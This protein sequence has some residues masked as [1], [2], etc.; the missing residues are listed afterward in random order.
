MKYYSITY[1]RNRKGHYLNIYFI[2]SLRS[3]SDHH[4]DLMACLSEIQ[5]VV[6]TPFPPVNSGG[7]MYDKL[8]NSP[9]LPHLLW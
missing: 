3:H 2:L 8:Y 4:K 7:P 1:I 5:R 9:T 6:E